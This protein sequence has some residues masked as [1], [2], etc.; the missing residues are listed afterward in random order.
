MAVGE[1]RWSGSMGNVS[2]NAGCGGSRENH[3]WKGSEQFMVLE[4]GSEIIRE[5]HVAAR[6]PLFRPPHH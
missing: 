2:V 1:W 5:G 4:G 3:F 6:K